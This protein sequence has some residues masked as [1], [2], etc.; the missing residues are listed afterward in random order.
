[1]TTN[2]FLI[3][4]VNDGLRKD[5]KPFAIPEDAFEVLNNAYQWRGRIKRRLGYTLLGNLA[6]GT[7]VMGLRTRELFG[8]NLQELIAFDLT[9]SYLFS[10]GAFIPLPSVMPTVWTGTNYQFFWTTNYA[11]AFWET[12]YVPG[13][14]GYAVTLFAGSAGPPFITNVTAAGNNFQVNDIVYFLNINSGTSLNNL[15]QAQVTVAGNPFTVKAIDGKGAFTDEA[16]SP[17]IVLS[18]TRSKTGQD[19][20]RFYAN[21]SNVIAGVTTPIG[22]SW[23]NYNPP[24]DV[25]FALAGALLIFAYRGYLVFLNTWEGNDQGVF[26]F[27]NR[28]RWTSLGTPFY[29]NPTPNSPSQVGFNPEAMRDDL[30]NGAAALDAPTNEA[31]VSA[32]FIKDI[33]VVEFERSTWRLRFV[34]NAQNPFVWERTNIEYGSDSTFSAIP[35]DKGLMTVGNRGIIISD[36]NDVIRFDD[37]IPSDVFDIRAENNGFERIYGIRTFRTRLCYWTYP[38]EEVPNGIFPDKVL[39][40]N[41]DT[42]NW[43]YFDDSFTC[44]G[45]F[46]PA[47]AA[48][49]WA[50][51]TDNWSTYDL[52]WDSGL[53]SFSEEVVIAGNQQGY[54]F[55]LEQDSS[56]NSPSLSIT[57]ILGSTITSANHNLRLGS[58]IILSGVTG[59]TDADGTTLNGKSFKVTPLTLNTFSISQFSPGT[60]PNASPTSTELSYSFQIDF[61][62]II[63]YSV[64][65]YIGNDLYTDNQGIL[66]GPNGLGIIDYDTGAFSISFGIPYTNTQVNIYVVGYNDLQ[67][68]IP[69]STTGAYSGGGQITVVSN[70]NIQTKIFNFFK[71]NKRSRLSRIDFYTNETANGQFTCNVFADSSNAVVNTPLPDNLQSNV[72][73]T[74]TNPYQFGKGEQTIYRLYCDA[75][76][77]TVQLQFTLSDRQMAVPT[78]N[79]TDLEIISLMMIVKKGGRLV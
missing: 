76:A 44:F 6:N 20:I 49:T 57:G 27:P 21:V 58:W 22:K 69:V 14:H 33:L 8:I 34:N 73:L 56:Q 63:P 9:N 55:A 77:Q 78:I 67:T 11:L 13:L 36:T 30:F 68:I 40:Y 4:P 38:S 79:Q 32:G 2:S 26:N 1:M 52:T 72:V 66:S 51:M 18:S 74:S 42:K 29:T 53:D 16:V 39:V 12:N 41:Y 45:Y 61:V 19:G 75:I 7:P 62:P 43:S 37:K 48:Q 60:A 65:I 3:G 31:I 64:K 70:F 54:V 28:A 46:Y 5:V 17:G 71:D 47:A 10:A 15:R 25:A 50:D 35:F 59:T 23:V 24:I